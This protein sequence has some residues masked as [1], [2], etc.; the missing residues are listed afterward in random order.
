M[1][2]LPLEP[3]AG[4]I[5]TS[6]AIDD[7][8]ATIN[9]QLRMA[10]S[11]QAGTQVDSTWTPTNAQGKKGNRAILALYGQR[12]HVEVVHGTQ[13]LESMQRKLICF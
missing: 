4:A 7:Q 6:S 10:S 2:A 13:L 11:W 3:A 9:A 12:F 8:A 1:S 5:T